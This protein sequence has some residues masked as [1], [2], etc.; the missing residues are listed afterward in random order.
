MIGGAEGR[1]WGQGEMGKDTLPIPTQGRTRALR[2]I[3]PHTHSP[4]P[5]AWPVAASDRPTARPQAALVGHGG[6]VGSS[7]QAMALLSDVAAGLAALHA[8][9]IVHRD[10]KPHNVLITDGRR[11]KLSDM[12][13]SKQ[14]VAEQSSF[15][16]HGAGALAW[17]A[18]ASTPG[19]CSLCA[20]LESS[21][22]RYLE[23]HSLCGV[24]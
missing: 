23:P 9:A 16:S 21:R 3:H 20:R 22:G 10:L 15:E 1:G 2:S 17:E 7:P 18:C 8:R 14:L 4:Q 5:F 24:R 19:C 11:A 6:P 12:G 13:L